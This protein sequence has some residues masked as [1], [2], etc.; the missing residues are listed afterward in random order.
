MDLS[1]EIAFR[2]NGADQIHFNLA[3]MSDLRGVLAEGRGFY[4]GS[5]VRVTSWEFSQVIDNPVLRSKTFFHLP[6][7]SVI[8]GPQFSF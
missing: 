1:Q 4:L 3:E 2:M 7:G 8:P 5:S 6:G